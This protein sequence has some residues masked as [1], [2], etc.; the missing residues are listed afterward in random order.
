MSLIREA[1]QRSGG[2]A[3]SQKVLLSQRFFIKTRGAWTSAVSMSLWTSYISFG[4]EW[5][6]MKGQNSRPRP[7]RASPEVSLHSYGVQPNAQRRT[8]HYTF[9][10]TSKTGRLFKEGIQSRA[11][12]H[13][14]IF[15]SQRRQISRGVTT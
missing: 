15:N 9:R 11:D 7:F 4:T 1:R 6:Q 13:D 14:N 2:M 5:R 10:A 12:S 3:R 8:A